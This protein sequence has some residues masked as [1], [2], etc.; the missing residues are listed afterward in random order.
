MKHIILTGGWGKEVP[1]NLKEHAT[2]IR[3]NLWKEWNSTEEMHAICHYQY[4]KHNWL[5]KAKSS[6]VRHIFILIKTVEGQDVWKYSHAVNYYNCNTSE[7]AKRGKYDITTCWPF[8]SY[9][10]TSKYQY[11]PREVLT[12]VGEDY[13]DIYKA[14]KINWQKGALV[15]RRAKY[16]KLTNAQIDALITKIMITK[17]WAYVETCQSQEWPIS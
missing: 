14:N 8:L 10:K 16:N 17:S 5:S 4:S 1:G 12:I 7:Y 6:L 15:N 11:V 13:Q 2:I 9:A 3:E